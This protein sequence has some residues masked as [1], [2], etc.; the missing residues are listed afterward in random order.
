MRCAAALPLVFVALALGAPTA[1]ADR[2]DH[3]H[4]DHR[5]GPPYPPGFVRPP[6]HYVFDR[7]FHH[8][9]YYPAP[10]FVVNAL[11]PGYLDI[12]ARRGHFFFNAGIWYRPFGGRY[13]V[14]V[15]PPGLFVPVLPPAYTTLWVG[16]T[17][18]YYAND[19]Y[20]TQVPGGYSVATPPPDFDP[21]L[22]APADAPPPTR[23]VEPPPSEAAAVGAS[24][25]KLFVY[26]KNGQS[27]Q[28]TQ[29]D[30]TDCERWA[31]RQ[32]GYDPA[33]G[34]DDDSGLQNYQRAET[35]CLE[36]RG[37]TVK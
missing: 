6:P 17:P 20:Y 37:Y 27:A 11:P 35:A 4:R 34:R 5:R 10:G 31:S 21:A 25:D 29:S 23:Y 14:A 26:P 8:D 28:Q 22:V 24:V 18:Y 9:R 19:V 32:T 16:A 1:H 33:R 30:Q 15:P 7:R 36:G 12:G 13:V 3:D 2:D